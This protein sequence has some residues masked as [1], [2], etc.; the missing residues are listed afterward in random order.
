MRTTRLRVVWAL[1]LVSVVLS[2]AP[3]PAAATEFTVTTSADTVAADGLT[4]LREA[5][6]EAS[7]N[8]VDDLII[9][10]GTESYVLSDCGAGALQY[11]D[12][13]DL[14]VQG[15]GATIEQTC[16]GESIV[17]KTGPNDNVL[18]LAQL[19][20]VVGPNGGGNV[21]G[22][23]VNATSQLILENVVIDGGD[24]GFSGTMIDID[25]GDAE[26]DLI[27][28]DSSISNNIGSGTGNGNPVGVLIEGSSVSNNSGSGVGV[29]DGTP[30][31]V[32]DSA[33]DGNGG[34]GIVTSGQG[35]GIQPRVTI[36]DSSVSDNDGGGMFCLSSCRTLEV[37]NSQLNGNGASPVPGRGGGVSMPIVLAGGDLPIVTITD[38]S[39]SDNLADHPGAGVFVYPT[40]E[41]DGPDQPNVTIADSV[42]DGNEATCADCN[43]GGVAVSVGNLTIERSSISNN[44]ATGNGGGVAFER[45]DTATIV[46]GSTFDLVDSTV[47]SNQAGGDGGGLW[48][49]SNAAAIVAGAIADNTAAS[50]G[51]G[52]SVGGVMNDDLTVSGVAE[53][54]LSTVSNNSAA[55]GGGVRVSAPDGSKVSVEQSTVDGNSASVSGGGFFVSPTSLLDLDYATVTRN[56]SAA[57]ANIA[58]NGPTTVDHSVVAEPV[59]GVNCGFILPPAPVFVVPNL[60]SQGTNWFDDVS[61]ADVAGDTVA[62][63]T[64]PEL[65]DLVDNGGVTPTR[66]P[67]VDSPLAG[68]IESALC[69]ATQ[70]QRGSS[71][72]A[73]FGCE[74]GAVEIANAVPDPPAGFPAS[75]TPNGDLRINGTNASEG[76]VVEAFGDYVDVSYDA[77]LTDPTNVIVVAPIAGPFR[78]VRADLRGGDDSLELTRVSVDRD[79]RVDGDSGDDRM[80]LNEVLA[81]RDA[82][83][84]GGPGEDRVEVLLTQVGRQ[85]IVSTGNDSDQVQIFDSNMESLSINTGSGADQAQFSGGVVSGGATAVLGSGSDR[86]ILAEL[87][88]EDVF[89]RGG[90]GDDQLSVFVSS[91]DDD[92]RFMGDG[93]ADQLILVDSSINARSFFNGG[94][95]TDTYLPDFLTTFAEPPLVISFE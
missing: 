90:S 22:H 64:S 59:T 42:I 11:F 44:T 28:R 13:A 6:I 63:G 70:D 92:F 34:V 7:S 8:G 46:E 40:F 19:D 3:N 68:L 62:P 30:I 91:I 26:F 24:A 83:L 51:G 79:V 89:V 16:A 49:Q 25:F 54:S 15:N 74:P 86:L 66:L 4:S 10:D 39:I 87:A 29:S 20:L 77:D 65:G 85:L 58:S 60:Q 37:T 88:M 93:G 27:I 71:R 56:D 57:G 95:G 31:R 67:S 73:G 35:F 12:T 41:S 80:A 48:I 5:M 21:F 84:V 9:L 81:V 1:A 76:L 78:D 69:G 2:S 38:S 43:G 75:R 94:G 47:L 45:S 18:T 50:A 36:I 23:A 82:R 33:I 52:I 17:E 32:V 61:C 55:S 53:I 72:P 14:V